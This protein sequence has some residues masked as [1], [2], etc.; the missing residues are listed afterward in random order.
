MH[1]STYKIK[2][3]QD[4]VRVHHNGDWSGEAIVSF[5]EEV[6]GAWDK[7]DKPLQEV[8]IPARLLAAL[9]LP[10]TKNMVSEALQRF[11]EV[12]P[13]TLGLMKAVKAVKAQRKSKKPKR[14]GKR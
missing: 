9:A 5:K 3:Y 11:A 14:K 10:V 6:F 2:G 1:T 13:E 12:L 8:T 7:Q 4:V